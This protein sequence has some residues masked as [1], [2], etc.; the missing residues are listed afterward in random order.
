M[1]RKRT[2]VKNN[3]SYEHNNLYD[4]LLS[5]PECYIYRNYGHKDANCLLRN[6]KPDLNPTAEN[7][8]I[9]KKKE[10]DKCRLVLSS[11]REK[12]LWYIDNGCSKHMFGDKSKFL[13][14]SESKSGNVD[15]W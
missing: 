14:L 9:W 1:A 5:E 6:F 3:N 10:D 4:L 2:Q 11:Q 7:F 13:T 8:K 12:N 15:G